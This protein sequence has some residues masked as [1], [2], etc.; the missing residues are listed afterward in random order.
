M[1][2][3]LVG[4]SDSRHAV[5][6]VDRSWIT[7]KVPSLSCVL[8]RQLKALKASSYS[9]GVGALVQQ[10]NGLTISNGNFTQAGG[11]VSIQNHFYG[12]TGPSITI[13]EILRRVPNMR[14]IHLDILSKATTGTGIW[15]LKTKKFTLWLDPSSGLRIL[16][17]TGIRKCTRNPSAS[18]SSYV[19]SSLASWCGED[20]HG[21]NC[22]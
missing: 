1:N 9:S 10:V 15:V 12:Q 2:T 14:K 22:H 16:W 4:W 13:S 17:G 20:C 6:R 18:L 5:V 21:I 8:N 7:F 11:N 3:K 19:F